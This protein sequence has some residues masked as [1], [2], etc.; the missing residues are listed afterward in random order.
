MIST[1]NMPAEVFPPGDFIREELEERGWTQEDLA[2][3]L[4]RSIRL[5]NEIIMGKR[6]IK[7]AT[8]NA[9]GAAFEQAVLSCVS[10]GK[11]N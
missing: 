4:G 1:K 8:A 3:I 6:G 11:E 5:V 9:L 2:A 10:N 7:P